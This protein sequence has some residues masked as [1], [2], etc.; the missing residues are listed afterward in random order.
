MNQRGLEGLRYRIISG[1]LST[2][3]VS[4]EEL[5]GLEKSSLK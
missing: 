3:D 2:M 4:A 5:A 1:D